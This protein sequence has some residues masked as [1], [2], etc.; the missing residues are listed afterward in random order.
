MNDNFDVEGFLRRSPVG[1]DSGVKR[2]VMARFEDKS[3]TRR[4]SPGRTA[5]W[6]RPVPLYAAVAGLILSIGIAFLA[7]RGTT[8]FD[9]RG[10]AVRE[11]S[12]QVRVN[13]RAEPE[14]V[15]AENDLL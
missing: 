11:E 7:G 14:W 10:D 6:K 4:R 13:E 9:R 5:F 2:S 3:G 12:P 15:V 1:P 8:W